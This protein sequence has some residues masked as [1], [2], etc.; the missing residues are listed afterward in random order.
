MIDF[1]RP[2][3]YWLSV[4]GE[5][6]S[7]ASASSSK[8]KTLKKLWRSEFLFDRYSK[9]NAV[10]TRIHSSTLQF[11]RFHI[12]TERPIDVQQTSFKCSDVLTTSLQ[13]PWDVCAHRVEFRKNLNKTF[14]LF[15]LL[16]LQCIY[17]VSECPIIMIQRAWSFNYRMSKMFDMK[18][19]VGSDKYFKLKSD[20][21]R[22]GARFISFNFRDTYREKKNF[23]SYKI[24]CNQFS[25]S[26]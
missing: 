19:P 16:N 10:Y 1:K 4:I 18:T 25:Q 21:G 8:V 6:L 23:H 17:F 14:H 26:S 20:K 24:F 15:S 2:G 7:S 22:R 13:R 3:G 11:C 5:S 9:C 12:G